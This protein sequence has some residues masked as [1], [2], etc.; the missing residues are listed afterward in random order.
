MALQLSQAPVR[1]GKVCESQG[2]ARCNLCL[3]EP[4]F[5]SEGASCLPATPSIVTFPI[6]RK[7][8]YDPIITQMSS[9]TIYKGKILNLVAWSRNWVFMNH[10]SI[11][12]VS[13]MGSTK[14]YKASSL[15]RQSSKLHPVSSCALKHTATPGHCFRSAL[16]REAH[17][18][19]S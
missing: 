9:P 16:A 3:T 14:S 19:G 18:Q 13:G 15:I 17:G 6:T 4:F 5:F 11:P 1:N 12:W 10:A 8:I 2:L 7:N